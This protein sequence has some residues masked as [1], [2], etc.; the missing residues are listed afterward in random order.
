MVLSDISNI[1]RQYTPEINYSFSQ[2]GLNLQS[3]SNTESFRTRCYFDSHSRTI[4]PISTR[5]RN[6]FFLFLNFFEPQEGDFVGFRYRA[7]TGITIFIRT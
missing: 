1:A 6:S 5:Y 7:V 2:N 4:Q 3:K